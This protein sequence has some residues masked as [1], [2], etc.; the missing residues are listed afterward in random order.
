M[1]GCKLYLGDNLSVIRNHIADESVNLVYADP[2][3]NSGKDYFLQRKSAK[4]SVSKF[5]FKDRWKWDATAVRDIA[6]LKEAGGEVGKLFASMEVF[7]GK[8]PLLSYL[9]H[10]APRLQEIWRVLK[11]DGSFYLHCDDSASAY[12][13]FVTDVIFGIHN[14]RDEI[15]WKRTYGG[16]GDNKRGMA[17]VCDYILVWVKNCSE[18]MLHPFYFE[19]VGTMWDDIKPIGSQAKERNGYP[20][21]KPVALLERILKLSS[22]PGDVVLDPYGGGGTT[23][24]AAQKLGRDWIAIDLATASIEVQKARLQEEFGLVEGQDYKLITVADTELPAKPAVTE[25]PVSR[26]V[27]ELEQ[28]VAQQHAEIQDLKAKNNYQKKLIEVL[29]ESSELLM[30]K[31]ARQQRWSF[32]WRLIAKLRRGQ[33]KETLRALCWLDDMLDEAFTG[34]PEETQYDF[35][36]DNFSWREYLT[37]KIIER[38]TLT[39]GGTNGTNN[40]TRQSHQPQTALGVAHGEQL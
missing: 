16:H 1:S 23:I 9:V 24:A 25:K 6:E 22:N 38:Q 35:D 12:L 14:F 30:A 7:V 20:T 34:L 39:K 4:G 28:L 18:P 10:M 19:E 3:F 33:Y 27:E 26:T 37:A 31:Y 21:Q 5:A 11:S 17:R 15:V 8:T 40:T 29:G 13:R 36:G 32:H 2:P